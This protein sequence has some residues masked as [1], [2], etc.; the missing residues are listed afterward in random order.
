[1][2]NPKNN[3]GQILVLVALSL[4]VLLG[5]AALAIDIG[6]FYH[7]KNQLQ[8]AADA[9]ALAGAA[10]LDIYST[11]TSIAPRAEALKYANLNSASGSPVQLIIDYNS[12]A[13]SS[14]NDITLGSW[15]SNMFDPEGTPVNAVRVKARKTDKDTAGFPRLFGK[16]FDSTN[17]NISAEAIATVQILKKPTIALCDS[18]CGTT[19][20]LTSTPPG[21]Q[22]CI[23]NGACPSGLPRTAWTG[24]EAGHGASHISDYWKGEGDVTNKNLPAQQY[25]EKHI[26][27]N[28][29]EV[30]SVFDTVSD[31]V[32]TGSMTYLVNGV[33]VIG[34]KVLI[35]VFSECADPGSPSG[36]HPITKL[37]V[38]IFTKV[39][40][41]GSD[42]YFY[43]VGAEN[44]DPG[45]S[46]FTCYECGTPEGSKLES[47]AV[48]L[49]K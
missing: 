32:L 11:P 38:G 33:D 44:A 23:S 12:N 41:S 14:S 48:R 22:F 49:V 42:A 31:I 30:A 5:F 40:K 29:G 34:Y 25:C 7:T 21:T 20:P 4:I 9:A 1:M 27:T 28:N 45:Y 43:I 36:Y 24:W 16:I 37:T 10:K 39:E 17:Q 6:Y 2:V 3:R 15:V 8:G 35:P 47:T 13:L 46:V 18:I 19:T 26:D